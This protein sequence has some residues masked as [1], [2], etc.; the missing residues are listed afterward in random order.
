[1][2]QLKLGKMMATTRVS[3]CLERTILPA[4]IIGSLPVS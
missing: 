3:D 1:M 2:T 4:Y